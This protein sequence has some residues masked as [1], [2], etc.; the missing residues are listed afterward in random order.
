MRPRGMRPQA[1]ALGMSPSG[2]C[3]APLRR[4]QCARALAGPLGRGILALPSQFGTDVHAPDPPSPPPFYTAEALAGLVA[5]GIAE[6]GAHTYGRPRVHWWREPVRLIIGRYTSIADGVEILLGGNHRADWVTTY[7]FTALGH[8]WP[9]AAGITGHPASKGDVRIGSDVWLGMGATILSGVTIGDGAVVGARAVVASNVPPFA[10][11]AG[12]PA[13]ILRY[14]FDRRR[15]D[16]LL[17]IRWWDWPDEKVRAH[18]RR[19]VS[20]DVDGF[21]ARFRPR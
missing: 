14:R 19:L 15:I 2:P 1:Q 21:I 4:C 11:V 12:N 18:V 17:A 9:E 7:P 20:G 16:A 8:L 5:A 13:R 10:V 3:C 6:I